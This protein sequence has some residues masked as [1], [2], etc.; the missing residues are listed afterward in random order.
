MNDRIIDE[1][2]IFKVS[3]FEEASVDY[4]TVPETDVPYVVADNFYKDV[5][6]VREFAN[7]LPYTKSSYICN[8][9]PGRRVRLELDIREIQKIAL[10]L[11]KIPNWLAI[12]IEP[13]V[14]FNKMRSNDVLKAEQ[15]NPHIDAPKGYT[16]GFNCA[17]VLYLN[18][19]E[20]CRGGTGF[21][22]HKG[23]GLIQVRNKYESTVFHKYFKGKAINFGRFMNESNEEWE[24]IDLI[25][26]KSN[27]AIFYPSNVFHS[28]Y[29][30]EGDFTE[31]DRFTQLGFF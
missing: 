26:M 27:R 4:R 16:A 17:M 22:K 31:Y 3:Q 25:E 6:K 29:I 11:L 21:Y 1:F 28:P 10:G 12:D 23:T 15:T 19:P 8:S 7:S 20:E 13:R 5:E 2:D 9:S 24:L 30:N 18:T 14:I